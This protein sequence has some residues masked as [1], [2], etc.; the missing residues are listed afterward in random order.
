MLIIAIFYFKE[1]TKNKANEKDDD[2]EVKVEKEV[3][4]KE[5]PFMGHYE[6]VKPAKKPSSMK[7]KYRDLDGDYIPSGHKRDVDRDYVPR[8]LS[9]A[10]PGQLR[11]CTFCSN[12]YDKT[13]N[14]KNHTLNHFL[15]KIKSFLPKNKPFQCP[16]CGLV[17]RDIITLA[18]HYAFTHKNVYD[19]CSEEELR[20]VPV[21]KK[22]D[23]DDGDYIP[24]NGQAES[25]EP[26]LLGHQIGA[27]DKTDSED[28]D[29]E[30]TNTNNTSKTKDYKM[31]ETPT[32]SNEDKNSEPSSPADLDEKLEDFANSELEN[33]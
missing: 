24:P 7:N 18:R 21:N 16:T 8:G 13:S 32:K 20:G 25:E 15:E 27:Q 6:K 33:V 11:K 5:L 26:R 2:D 19:Y 23:D 29:E 31:A 1:C 9:D 12:Q 17:Q 22:S 4:Y 28:E 10:K 30:N 14:M 3:G